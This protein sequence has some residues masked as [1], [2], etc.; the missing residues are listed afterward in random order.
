VGSILLPGS[1]LLVGPGALAKPL[2]GFAGPRI[3]R[4]TGPAFP[5][6]GEDREYAPPWAV[7][8]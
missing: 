2:S 7:P 6:A 8:S 4:Y 5:R 1:L 3:E